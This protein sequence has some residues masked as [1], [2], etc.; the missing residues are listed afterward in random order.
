VLLHEQ[1]RSF[2]GVLIAKKESE[3][4]YEMDTSS[5]TLANGK[6]ILVCVYFL[7]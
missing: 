6:S 3:K 4:F 5:Q 1:A 7:G 2:Y